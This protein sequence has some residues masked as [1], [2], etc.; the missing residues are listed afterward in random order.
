MSGCPQYRRYM[1]GHPDGLQH[2]TVHLPA[3]APHVLRAS[4]RFAGS[5]CP[6]ARTCTPVT[7]G[8]RTLHGTKPSTCPHMH[9]GYCGHPDVSVTLGAEKWAE[10]HSTRTVSGIA[11]QSPTALF[12]EWH[13]CPVFCHNVLKPGSLTRRNVL[14]HRFVTRRNVSNRHTDTRHFVSDRHDVTRRNV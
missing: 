11:Q 13:I 12:R 6:L 9:P 2:E 14:N 5:N 4:G 7:A 1:C 8:I 3:H 10:F